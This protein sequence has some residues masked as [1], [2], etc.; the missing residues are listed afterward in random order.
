M[1]A[2]RRLVDLYRSGGAS[3]VLRGVRDF[4]RNRLPYYYTVR[5]EL[6]PDWRKLV[7]CDVSV[8]LDTSTP[9]LVKRFVTAGT[10]RALLADFVST[11]RPDD[12][13]WDIG[14]NVGLY[15]CLASAR[16]ADTVAF[17][18]IPANATLI[19]RNAAANDLS[20]RVFETALGA[21][22]GTA[23]I[24]NLADDTDA[25][26]GGNY[27]ISTTARAVTETLDVSVSR[28]DAYVADGDLS[29]PT[30]VKIDVEGAEADVLDGLSTVLAEYPPRVIYVEVHESEL[31]AFGASAT[32]VHDR[33]RDAGY[34]L[35]RLHSRD[36]EN[37]HLKATRSD[38]E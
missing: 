27:A 21:E 11:V 19:R 29:P 4:L 22:P 25:D 20:V 35:E 26:A 12:A 30:V 9:T 32:G 1:Q 7:V 37:Y 24:P 38:A 2:L 16:G 6:S 3:E 13:C 15:A 36:E 8:R 5:N 28:G 33:L 23:Q 14:A 31:P 10:E 17:E 18:P 34:T